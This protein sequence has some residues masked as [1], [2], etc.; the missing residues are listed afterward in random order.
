MAALS[1]LFLRTQSLCRL[2]LILVLLLRLSRVSLHHEHD[3]I[4]FIREAL[5]PML[6]MIVV[7][8]GEGFQ[9]LKPVL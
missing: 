9:K 4:V 6:E 5:G 7:K 3:D 8:I 2:I 1:R